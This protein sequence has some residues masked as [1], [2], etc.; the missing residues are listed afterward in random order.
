MTG[1]ASD[2]RRRVRTTLEPTPREDLLGK[3][4][5]P[6][7]VDPMTQDRS[8]SARLKKDQ[9]DDDSTILNLDELLAR[10]KISLR[11]VQKFYFQWILLL[12]GHAMLFFYLPMQGNDKL[13]GTS[14]CDPSKLAENDASSSNLQYQC[15]DL[16]QNKSIAIFY[17]LCCFYFY[18]SA[19]QVKHGLPE[20]LTSYFMLSRYHWLNKYIFLG[21]Y[22]IPFIFELRTIIDWT[23]TKSSL[24]VYQWIKLSQIQTDLYK[25][26]CN[27]LF[28]MRKK[29]GEP[30]PSW[31]R[32]SVGLGLM[33]LILVLSLGPMF[34]FS[35]FDIFGDYNPVQSVTIQLSLVVSAGA[36]KIPQKLFETSSILVKEVL[37]EHQYDSIMQFGNSYD[38]RSYERNQVQY[39]IMNDYSQEKWA[40]SPKVTGNIVRTLEAAKTRPDDEFKESVYVE[41]RYLFS[42]SY[43]K[44]ALSPIG[45]QTLYLNDPLIGE[46]KED[47]V[48]AFINALTLDCDNATATERS[49]QIT[50]GGFQPLIA[51]G[52]TLNV[53][54]LQYK[55][56]Q[57]A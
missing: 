5:Q 19:V 49:Q 31:Y 16:N 35:S 27:N 23:Y 14:Y 57:Q 26:K 6:D 28:Y 4:L 41:V 22:N 48:D 50:L 40:V 47:V 1:G 18:V 36:R 55:L 34:L 17:I 20:V 29:T 56:L 2:Q 25:A 13:H 38:T 3:Q 51:L 10:S 8:A 21:F 43:P 24:D 45:N 9:C 42:R 54:Q 11:T 33:A 12:G 7:L 52:Q 37:T 30:L 44:S 53:E 46:S 15:N 39:I 32:Y